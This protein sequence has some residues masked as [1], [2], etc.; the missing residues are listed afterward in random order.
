MIIIIKTT[1][2]KYDFD[3]GKNCTKPKSHLHLDF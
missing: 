3:G 2:I 1:K